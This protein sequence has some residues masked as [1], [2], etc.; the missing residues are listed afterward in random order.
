MNWF[1]PALV[2]S[3]P[4]SGGG[5]SEDEGTR[6]WSRSSKKRRNDSRIRSPSMT[7]Q[8][9]GDHAPD[10]AGRAVG[11]ASGRKS[12]RVAEPLAP[13][14]RECHRREPTVVD[15]DHVAG[16]HGQ[17][18]L[19]GGTWRHCPSGAR[20]VAAIPIQLALWVTIVVR[21]P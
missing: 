21:L 6:L 12:E 2:S 10:R 18:G 1:I 8:S 17:F 5:I 3:S 13:K 9:I 11:L 19:E 4:D 15:H 7:A 14:R 20:R 16:G